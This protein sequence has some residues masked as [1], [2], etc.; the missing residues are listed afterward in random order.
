MAAQ[1]GS[2][3]GHAVLRLEGVTKRFAD[4]LA[5]DGID[6]ALDEGEILALLGENGAGKTTLMSILFGHYVADEGTVE[7]AG[8]DGRLEVLPPGRPGTALAKGVG[9]VHQH[10][11]LALNLTV[12][13]NIV[14][15]TEPLWS[16][17][18]KRAGARARLEGLMADSGLKVPLDEPV[19]RLSVGER[20]RVEILKALYREVRVLILDE[21]TAVLTPQ[22]ADGLFITLKGL[23]ER[24]LA[25]IFISHKLAEVMAISR[26]VVVLRQGRKVADLPTAEA[27]RGRLAE[28]MVGRKVELPARDAADPGRSVLLAL[29]GVHMAGE[30]GRAGLE[31]VGLALHA[32]EIV[33]I[34]GVAGNGQQALSRLLFGLAPPEAG[35]VSLFGQPVRRFSPARMVEAG[36]ARIPEDRHHEGVIGDMPLWENLILE[37]C[38]EPRRHRFGVI[39]RKAARRRAEELIE[40]YNVRGA[41]IDSAARLLSGGNLQKLILARN[42]TRA[43]RLIVA[44]QPTRG[45]DIGAVAHVHRLLLEARRRGAGVI[46]ISEDLDELLALADRIAVIHA[47]RLTDPL[48][49]EGLDARKLGL[50]MAGHPADEVLDAA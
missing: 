27:D 37:D 29:E 8:A 25:I 43:P 12:L 14:L 4:T 45:L 3:A 18:S 35:R 9:M 15:G 34:A 49:V 11:T 33:G 39:R 40:Q 10:F 17:R 1:A 6:L 21:P 47:G 5:N 19:V 20:Q 48:P 42:F 24:G 16:P 22:E 41:G 23:A 2:G 31:D 7:V 44:N 36:V 13:D 32:H 28:L 26:R 30:R 46:L 38:R 50:M